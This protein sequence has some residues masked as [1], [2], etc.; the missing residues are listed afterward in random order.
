MRSRLVHYTIN[1]A[2]TFDCSSK[3]FDATVIRSLAPIVN[4]A[5]AEVQ[6]QSALPSPMEAYSLNFPSPKGTGIPAHPE[7]ATAG[8]SNIPLDPQ[9]QLLY[10]VAIG[11]TFLL[12]F[13]SST[14]SQIGT[15]DILPLLAL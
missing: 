10:S 6:T 9:N 7:R 2:A 15:L 4:R 1:S 3:N 14:L 8:H 13:Q 5:I 12:C 11:L